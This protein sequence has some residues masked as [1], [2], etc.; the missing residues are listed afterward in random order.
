MRALRGTGRTLLWL[1]L[2]C[3]T[4]TTALAPAAA[5]KARLRSLLAPVEDDLFCDPVTKAPLARTVRLD[6]NGAVR[7]VLR[8]GDGAYGEKRGG[9]VDL[10]A[11]PPRTA[12]RA[13]RDALARSPAARVRE[14]TFRSPVVSFLYERGWR[15]SFRR[16]GFPGVAAEFVEVRDFFDDA[17]ARGGGVILDL[18]CGT[19]LMARRLARAG[20]AKSRVVAADFSESMLVETRRRARGANLE[21]VRCD[22]ARLPFR[23]GSVDA[24]HAGAALHCWVDVEAGLG[25]VA[26]ALKPGGK[27]FATTFLEGALGTD[28]L[29]TDA[30][31]YRFFTLGELER[32]LEAAGFVDVDVR[33]EG[34]F[35]AV[36]KAAA[37]AAAGPAPGGDYLDSL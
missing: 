17:F 7:T 6:G 30:R 26:R 36:V 15:E 29:P 19:G 5:P 3:A 23:T 2:E 9:Y 1:W 8:G 13:V 32:L 16:S 18:C 11:A 24:A 37:S 34:G 31:G 10:V 14:D 20:E 4:T 27:F 33:R 25:E 22:V 12:A 35:C 21:L 28:R